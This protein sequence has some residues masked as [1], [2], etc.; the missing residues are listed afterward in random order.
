VV[1]TTHIRRIGLSDLR[2]R[3]LITRNLKHDHSL[4]VS[5]D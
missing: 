2:S 4:V 1:A 5:K 3:V